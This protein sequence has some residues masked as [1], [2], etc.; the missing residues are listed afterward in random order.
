MRQD[1][2][3]SADENA[4]VDALWL[5]HETHFITEKHTPPLNRYIR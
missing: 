5:L 1:V 2:I 3:N 4:F